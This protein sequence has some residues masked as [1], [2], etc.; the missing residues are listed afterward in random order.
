MVSPWPLA[1]P[2]SAAV[3]RSATW[4]N[5]VSRLDTRTIRMLMASCVAAS[6]AT[7]S[8]NLSTSIWS[9]DLPWIYKV[10][11]SIVRHFSWHLEYYMLLLLTQFPELASNINYPVF[12]SC[13]E[14]CPNHFSWKFSIAGTAHCPVIMPGMISESI[15]AGIGYRWGDVSCSFRCGVPILLVLFCLFSQRNCLSSCSI[16][17]WFLAVIAWDRELCDSRGSMQ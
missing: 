12:S 10:S 5:N 8:I 13:L 4:N 14:M 7:R 1:G 16:H 9:G 6:C 2:S 3:S 17:C 15:P 11:I